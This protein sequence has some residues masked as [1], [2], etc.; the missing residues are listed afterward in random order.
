LRLEW[1]LPQDEHDPEGDE[2]EGPVH[3]ERERKRT[4]VARSNGAG[5]RRMSARGHRRIQPCTPV[6]VGQRPK[7]PTMSKRT[8]QDD[9][10]FAGK[11]GERG[12]RDNMWTSRGG[13]VE[14]STQ[15]SPTGLVESIAVCDDDD[16][17]RASSRPDR[18]RREVHPGHPCGL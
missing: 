12:E 15:G 18:G 7:R 4:T 6:S 16:Q 11:R 1:A 17:R 13:L 14:K 9:S 5:P 2:R 8:Y 10:W 3:G